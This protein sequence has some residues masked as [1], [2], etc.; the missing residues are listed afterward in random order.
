MDV[1]LVRLTDEQRDFAA[2][3][4]E[5][6]AAHVTDGVL[7]HERRTGDGFNEGVHLAL[8]KRGWI[9]PAWPVGLGGAG[10][11]PVQVRILELEASRSRMPFV[12]LGTTRMVTEAVQRHASDE[13]RS[14][15]LRGVAEGTV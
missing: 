4:R 5:F 3:A 9:M 8:G 13:I 12:T 1:S 10:L 15:L 14:G 7:E 2:R 6:F 11:D